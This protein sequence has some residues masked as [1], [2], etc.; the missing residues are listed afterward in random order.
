MG[1]G[2][3]VDAS[4]APTDARGGWGR[5][6]GAVSRAAQPPGPAQQAAP[7]ELIGVAIVLGSA[8]RSSSSSS[9]V[10]PAQMSL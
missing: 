5:G 7:H 1:C 9:A 6:R 2:V 3:V 4:T 10:C 8:P